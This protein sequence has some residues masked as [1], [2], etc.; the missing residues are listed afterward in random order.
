MPRVKKGIRGLEVER[1]TK[2]NSGSLPIHL[3][4][5]NIP[6]WSS[7]ISEQDFLPRD[8][9][10]GVL[11]TMEEVTGAPSQCRETM[12]GKFWPW[13]HIKQCMLFS[14]CMYTAAYC[15][16]LRP[17]S[18]LNMIQIDMFLYSS[19]EICTYSSDPHLVLASFS[20]CCD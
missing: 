13:L 19:R 8:W 11:R 17:S 3:T 12:K 14:V 20:C 18:L 16:R 1:T 5:A 6:A 15:R 10:G 2:A 4:P 7:E 9:T